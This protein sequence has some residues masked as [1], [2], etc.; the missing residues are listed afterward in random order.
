MNPSEKIKSRTSEI[1]L[2]E[3]RILFVKFF[4]DAEVEKEDVE[5]MFEIYRQLGCYN[6]KVLQLID[7][8]VNFSFSSEARS[9]AAEL[10]T[11]FFIAS[12]IISNSLA[13]RLVVNFFIRLNKPGV[14][15][16]MFPDEESALK[17]LRSFT[18]KQEKRESLG[19]F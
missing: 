6:N 3:E 7:G 13:T 2:D 19:V 9:R 1:W 17:W 12:A 5:E 8:R 18:K 11:K 10:G 14:P 16:K 15:F 4:K